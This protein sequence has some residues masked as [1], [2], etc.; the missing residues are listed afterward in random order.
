[1]HDERRLCVC[2]RGQ[3]VEENQSAHEDGRLSDS[4]GDGAVWVLHQRL[5]QVKELLSVA[6]D[7]IATTYHSPRDP[8]IR[9]AKYTISDPDARITDYENKLRELETT[10]LEGV[11]VQT[12]ITVVC[13]MNVVENLDVSDLL[14]L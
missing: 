1:M 3:A 5:H 4:A 7:F 12:G 6:T 11:V 10:F 14:E 2:R 13:M 8:G 9:T